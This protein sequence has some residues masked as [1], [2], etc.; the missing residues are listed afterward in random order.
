M[1]PLLMPLRTSFKPAFLAALMT[2]CSAVFGAEIGNP[3]DGSSDSH[4]QQPFG[5]YPR[6]QGQ[7]RHAGMDIWFDQITVEL[8]TDSNGN[9]YHS[10][11]SVLLDIDTWLAAWPVY[12][13]LSL[14]TTGACQSYYQ[15]EILTVSGTSAED[16]A[17]IT[18]TLSEPYVGGN[19]NLI[20]QLYD[21]DTHE[22][23]IQ[24]DAYTHPELSAIYLESAQADSH[25]NSAAYL[26]DIRF[27]LIADDDGDGF[28]SKFELTV[29][30][31]HPEYWSDVELILYLKGDNDTDWITLLHSDPFSVSG[32]SNLDKQSYI[33][34]LKSGYRAD[35]YHFRIRLIHTDSGQLLD[36]WDSIHSQRLPLESRDRDDDFYYPESP[37]VHV[38]AYAGGLPLITIALLLLLALIRRHTP[39]LH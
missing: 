39:S 25:I 11:F 17:L 4:F 12:A 26:D 3:A 27:R 2:L 33:L 21:A 5:G 35:F 15:T 22:L 38:E 28:Y 14:E 9:G 36:D 24:A 30:V 1:N 37:S 31:D 7:P 13:V 8:L 10:R 16:I 18:T 34:S 32:L 20:I 29:D 19:Y 6:M 23:I